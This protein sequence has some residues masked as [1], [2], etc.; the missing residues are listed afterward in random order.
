MAMK[1]RCDAVPKG[2]ESASNKLPLYARSDDG[3]VVDWRDFTQNSPVVRQ[4]IHLSPT[5]S[6]VQSW[7]D[8]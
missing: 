8:N 4:Y 1:E 6:R 7:S 2:F 5:T 3:L